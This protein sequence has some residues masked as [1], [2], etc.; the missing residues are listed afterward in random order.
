MQLLL[1]ALVAAS[2]AVVSSQSP[3]R[4]LPARRSYD[5]HHY[6]A[7]EIR[8]S[9][10]DIHPT[11]V[12][13][14]LG[15]EFIEQVG[16]LKHHYVVRSEKPLEETSEGAWA[17]TLSRRH[18]PVHEDPVLQRWATLS[19]ARQNP[20]LAKREL[21]EKRDIVVAHAIRGLERQELRIRHKR[22]KII[23]PWDT[24]HLYPQ[25]R[26]P[27]PGPEPRPYPDPLPRPP[28]LPAGKVAKMQDLHGIID[29]IFP[30]QWH[31]ANDKRNGYDLNVSGVW[32][33]GVTGKGVNVCLID[34]GLDMKSPDLV[35]N[36][37]SGG[38]DE[39]H[40]FWIRS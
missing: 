3:A 21:L 4:V 36:F 32:S 11:R 2:C 27:I 37:V 25:S 9:H 20:A 38:A 8:P 22:D 23:S 29:P 28:I 26:D 10:A 16:E 34:D 17:G 1:L 31:L 14:L 15:V 30:D 39:A 12:A 19:Q 13:E 40:G 7:L 5:T 33:A 18:L 24:P 6:Y 35:S